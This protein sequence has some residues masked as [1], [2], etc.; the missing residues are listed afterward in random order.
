MSARRRL[1]RD[2]APRRQ[3]HGVPALASCPRAGPA[4]RGGGARLRVGWV[5]G[6]AEGGEGAEEA[7][8]TRAAEEARSAGYRAG[9]AA[10]SRGRDV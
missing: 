9:G 1:A 2:S 8:E 3:P 10:G 6:G 4:G 5:A 7:G